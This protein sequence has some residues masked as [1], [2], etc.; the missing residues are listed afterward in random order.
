MVKKINSKLNKLFKY[1]SLINHNF[2]YDN[3]SINR[4]MPTKNLNNKDRESLLKNLKNSIKSIKNC[5][6]QLK[7]HYKNMSF[8]NSF[9]KFIRCYR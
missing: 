6:N 7:G 8:T 2:I 9:Q 1:Y 5:Q 3:K 4:Y